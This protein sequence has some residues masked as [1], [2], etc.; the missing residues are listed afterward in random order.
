M[1]KI[2]SEQNS[3]IFINT[4][5]ELLIFFFTLGGKR[6]NTALL[7]LKFESLFIVNFF[8]FKFLKYYSEVWFILITGGGG[9]V[10]PPLKFCTQGE[11]LTGPTLAQPQNKKIII[12]VTILILTH[13]YWAFTLWRAFR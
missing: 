5:L 6:L 10:P 4:G 8:N 1:G 13:G 3:K 11:C 9:L 2:D 7:F 12:I